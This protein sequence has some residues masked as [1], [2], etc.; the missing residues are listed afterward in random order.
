MNCYSKHILCAHSDS[1]NTLYFF[2]RTQI[3]TYPWLYCKNIIIIKILILMR[4]Q[5]KRVLLKKERKRMED[6]EKKGRIICIE[7]VS[8]TLSFLVFMLNAILTLS[9]SLTLDSFFLLHLPIFNTCV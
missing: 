6:C 8:S 9:L 2:F 7:S 5:K 3:P 4:K 1:L